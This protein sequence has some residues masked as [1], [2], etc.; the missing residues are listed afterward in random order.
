M[1]IRRRDFLKL[2]GPPLPGSIIRS[3]PAADTP[4]IYDLERFGNAR[5]LHITDT[6]A[7][8]QPVYFREPSVNIGIGDMAG[9]PPHLVAKAFLERYG[10]RADSAD[11]YAFTSIDFEKS[12]PR[13]GKLGGFAHLKTLIDK[14]RAEVGDR[15]S[16]LIDGGDLWQGTGLANLMRGADMVDAGNLLGIE[17]M[18]GHW[19]FT[20]GE[21][22]L[23]ANLARFKGEFLAQNVF[24]TEEAAFNDA[25]AFDPASGRVFKPAITKEIG[26]AH[27]AVIGQAFPYVPIAHPK[28]FTAD[29]TFGIREA[30]L[31]T[32]VD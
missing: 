4:G 28:R 29:W 3:A 24:L 7:Q 16:L 22:D 20:Y 18:T 10:I 23:R 17:A 31:Q 25:K 11:A 8:L 14:L 21:A 15:R 1:K 12:A 13:F 2:S 6:H 27:V 19:E 26:G 9:Q 5:I 30:E 32:L